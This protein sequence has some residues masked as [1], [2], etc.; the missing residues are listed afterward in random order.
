MISPISPYHPKFDH[1][2]DKVHPARR[3]AAEIYPMAWDLYLNS[4][5]DGILAG[6]CALSTTY[7]QDAS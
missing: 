7:R 4:L 1:D 2:L 6:S 3:A 5:I